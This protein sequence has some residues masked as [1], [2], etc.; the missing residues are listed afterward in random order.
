[1]DLPIRLEWRKGLRPKAP[2]LPY[3]AQI[4]NG[5]EVLTWVQGHGKWCQGIEGLGEDR[6]EDQELAEVFFAPLAEV[7]DE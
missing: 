2:R 6:Y 5:F 7:R 1:M 4:D 3:L